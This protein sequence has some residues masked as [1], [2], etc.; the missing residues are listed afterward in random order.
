MS[1]DRI[2]DYTITQELTNKHS[3]FAKWGFVE[4]NENEYFI[5]EFLAPVYPDENSPLSDEQKQKKI[6]ECNEWEKQKSNLYRSIRESANGNIIV[7]VDFFRENS[8]YYLVT[9]KVDSSFLS[10]EQIALLDIEKKLIIIKVIAHCLNQLSKIGVIHGDLKPDNLLVKKTLGEMYTVKLIDFDSSYFVNN[11]PMS[12]EIQCDPTYMSPETFLYMMG[13]N[14]GL[15]Q[16]SDVFSA[17][18]IFHQYLSGKL[19]E[20]SND[21]DYVYEAVLDDSSVLL[22]EAIP[23]R[24]RQIISMM[25]TKNP[26]E[27]LSVEYV[28]QLLIHTTPYSLYN[29][30]V[31]MVITGSSFNVKVKNVLKPSTDDEW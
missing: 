7:P 29:C 14:S 25:L 3:G 19:P 6:S 31:N 11:I 13:E 17:G 22:S 24:L 5:K 21:Y 15:N 10:C 1:K 18:L 23:P 20:F 12:D 16:R 27:R 9:E 2:H 4:K 28:Y 30:N 26:D 8:H